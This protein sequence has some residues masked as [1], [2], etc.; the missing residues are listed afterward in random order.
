MN[1]V[2]K[3]YGTDGIYNKLTNINSTKFIR[4]RHYKSVIPLNLFLTWSNKILPPKMQEHIDILTSLN[5]EFNIQ[6]F[7]CEERREFIKNHFTED[8][9][10]AYDNLIPGAYKAD[11]WRLCILYIKGGI[12]IDI[13]YK[14]INNFKFIALT[15]EEHFCLDRDGFFADGQPFWKQGNIGLY[16]A[17]IVS[18]PG[19]QIL[20]NT[21]NRISENVKNK[22]YSINNLYPT[23]P[24]LLGEEYINFFNND[25]KKL[26]Y[27]LDRLKMCMNN[28]QIIFNN[29]PILEFYSEYRN[30]QKSFAKIKKTYQE[31]YELSQVYVDDNVIE[32]FENDMFTTEN[33]LS[34]LIIMIFLLLL[35]KN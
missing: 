3:V 11:L 9:L 35:L 34:C 26:N 21:I 24:G 10:K 32:H 18:K 28:E 33:I 27:E 4:K 1:I 16:N 6:I 29:V 25:Q 2:E 20:L 31:L 14:C 23:G 8:I 17:I 5:S 22:D 30:E 19:N 12:Y 7:D 15:E 13:K